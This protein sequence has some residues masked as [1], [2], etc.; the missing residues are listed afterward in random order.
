MVTWND[1]AVDLRAADRSLILAEH[2]FELA[3]QKWA[4]LAEDIEELMAQWEQ[5]L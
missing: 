3:A 4:R 5:G 1:L 2:Y